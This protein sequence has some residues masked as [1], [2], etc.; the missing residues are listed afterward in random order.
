MTTA[1]HTAR[2]MH[3]K[4][5]YSIVG[6]LQRDLRR[7]PWTNSCDNAMRQYCDKTWWLRKK[8]SERPWTGAQINGLQRKVLIC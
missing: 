7:Y 3:H 6:Y 5:C 1:L 8:S 2:N 4:F